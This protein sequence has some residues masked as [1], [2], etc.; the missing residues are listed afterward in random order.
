M[1]FQPSSRA[2]FPT[3]HLTAGP[4]ACERTAL[5]IHVLRLHVIQQFRTGIVFG[6][7]FVPVA[8]ADN[9]PVRFT[10]AQPDA[11]GADCRKT[12]RF[13]LRQDRTLCAFRQAGRLE[14]RIDDGRS[15]EIG[16]WFADVDGGPIFQVFAF[17]LLDA[18][19]HKTFRRWQTRRRTVRLR[20]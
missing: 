14:F 5:R 2:R 19:Q 13:R 15:Q 16:D 12:N 3:V 8:H 17:L 4:L 9:S 20:R 18:F 6:I 11:I 7:A 1:P 10:N